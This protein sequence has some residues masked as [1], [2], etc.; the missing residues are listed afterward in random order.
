MQ[1]SM[2]REYHSFDVFLVFEVIS[3][4]EVCRAEL[5]ISPNCAAGFVVSLLM[6]RWAPISSHRDF[7]GLKVNC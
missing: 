5:M 3:T 2:A 1:R 6:T 4:V 7:R